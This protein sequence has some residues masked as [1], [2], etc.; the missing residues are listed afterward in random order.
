MATKKSPAKSRASSTS[1][2]KTAKTAKNEK[3]L[4][5]IL[6]FT[7]GLMLLFVAV[8]PGEKAWFALH[9]FLLG[10]FSWCAYLLGPI[11][12]Y[13]AVMI[14]MDKTNFP[15]SAKV[16][17]S[18]VL[19]L[20]FCG[21]SQIFWNHLPEGNLLDLFE[22][23]YAA[24]TALKGGGVAGIIF[25]V[26]L[27]LWLDFT[28]AAITIVLLIFVAIMIL[29]G[30]TIVGL[31]K[32]MTKPVRKME[33]V[34][35]TAVEN[36]AQIQETAPTQEPTRRN[37]IPEPASFTTMPP[38]QM[39]LNEAVKQNEASALQS[40]KQR[41]LGA[42][43]ET[44]PLVVEPPVDSGK[45]TRLYNF[46]ADATNED[47]ALDNAVDALERETKGVEEPKPRRFRHK[48]GETA[49][50]VIETEPTPRAVAP[51]PDDEWSIDAIISRAV[52]GETVVPDAPVIE[53]DNGYLN[54][55]E[56][57][58]HE[59]IVNEE[60]AKMANAPEL[61]EVQPETKLVPEP[62]AVAAPTQAIIQPEY[63][64]PPIELLQESKN[65]PKGDTTKELRANADRLV[66][67]LKSFGVQTR[68][69]D[70]SR[71]PAVTR[72]EL[73]PSAGVK[74]SKITNLAD[75][76]ALNLAAGGVRIEAP[77]PN[78]A[79]IGIE[80]PNK[81][82]S[83][84][85]IREIL[86]TEAFT[87]AKSKLSVVLGKDITGEPAVADIGKMPHVLIAGAT[88]SGKSVC[89]N[90]LIVS[91]LY[92]ATPDEVKLLMIDPKVVELGSYN[93]IPHLLSPVVTDPK[94]AAG[95]LCTMVGEMLRR[96]KL[97]ADCNVRDL[98]GY[99]KLAEEREDLQPMP[100]IVIII[101]ELADLMMASPKDVEDYICR[102]AQMARAAGMHLVIATQRP[103][104][105]VI[106]GVIK[107]NIPSRISFAVSSQIDSRTILDMG[108]A[109][110][111][112]G[113][114]D[115]LFYPVGSAKPTRIQGCF[116]TDNEVED[117]VSYIKNYSCANYDEQLIEEIEKNAAQVGS[118][119]SGTKANNSAD[120]GSDS[121]DELFDKAIE[122]VVEA[123]QASTSLLQR[124]LK[125][126]YARAARLVDEMEQAGIVGPFE[127]SKPRQVLIS[128]ERFYEMRAQSAQ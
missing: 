28:G 79:A 41:L 93:G 91:L 1:K 125:V 114:G 81:I 38:R 112:L 121:T 115:M 111:L 53:S 118:K 88:G 54:F 107:A 61:K 126:G 58:E 55:G 3:R 13:T 8:V 47:K 30:G 70:I 89:I 60:V 127:G 39:N 100:Q 52:S 11:I 34:Y 99:N 102:L 35:T 6:L 69:V 42:F 49:P 23:L 66:D 29:S 90:S 14:D 85:P 5:A 77:I 120:D 36:R 96:Y 45:N 10:C 108:G 62:P 32:G 86:E 78:K 9:Q 20:F 7:L 22:S 94:K 98:T 110:K 27:L 106:T 64:Y 84:V 4:Y 113:R 104:V 59:T 24:G 48:V 25:G 18:I 31:F 17:S 97:F 65:L 82:V 63:S 67:T 75:D 43:N 68:I 123:G 16:I 101:D 50:V 71:G 44:Q 117:V 80:V 109:E 37:R 73:Q 19:I 74:I 57:E 2:K 26:P 116:V 76:I 46:D 56:A 83:T 95:A 124:R 87:T 105:D 122:V 72:Y 128:K 15:I 119:G 21:A 51:D 33:E 40:S 92:K 12:I 103:S